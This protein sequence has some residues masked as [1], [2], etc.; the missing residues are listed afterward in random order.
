L[1]F[2]LSFVFFI[3][4]KIDKALKKI[5]LALT[6]F[7]Q[8]LDLILKA[9]QN[10]DPAY[11]LEIPDVDITSIDIVKKNEIVADYLGI[12]ETIRRNIISEKKI[13]VEFQALMGDGEELIRQLSQLFASYRYEAKAFNTNLTNI[14]GHIIAF[15]FS[16]KGYQDI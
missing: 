5:D 13:S 2:R 12:H 16:L 10:I 4:N 15:I 1:F 7:E 8:T 14:S 9:Y 6:K 3:K 11:Q